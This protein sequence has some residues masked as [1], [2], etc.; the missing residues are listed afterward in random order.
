MVQRGQGFLWTLMAIW[1]VDITTEPGCYRNT[2]PDMI[3]CG[4]L[5]L[6]VTMAPGG[7]PGYLD[8]IVPTAMC[9]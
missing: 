2:D 8:S 6:N 4:I 1:A 3:L 9:H 7:C 5:G